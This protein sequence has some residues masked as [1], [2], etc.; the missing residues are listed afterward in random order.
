MTALVII[1]ANIDGGLIT[2]GS[3][4][5]FGGVELTSQAFASGISWFPYVLTI[6]VI[7]FAFSTVQQQASV[8]LSASLMR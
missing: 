8:Q 4:G 7:L 1:I 5:G 3:D 6:A 2:Y